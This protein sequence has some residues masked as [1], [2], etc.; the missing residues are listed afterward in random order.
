M[1]RAGVPLK[2]SKTRDGNFVEDRIYNGKDFDKNI[3]V[4]ERRK[5][6]A[7]KITEFLKGSD[8]YAKTIVFCVDIEHAE[9]MRREL[10]NANADLVLYF[11][12]SVTYSM[13]LVG[14]R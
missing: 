12:N 11:I 4:E 5:L 2:A 8:R 13:R 10:V 6:V 3:I 7:E 14:I 1:P 9:G